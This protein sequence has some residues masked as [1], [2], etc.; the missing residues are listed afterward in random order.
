LLHSAGRDSSANGIYMRVL[1]TAGGTMKLQ[2]SADG[3][4]TGTVTYV[5]KFRRL[6]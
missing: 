2:L 3:T 5:I 1:R 6:I 4:S